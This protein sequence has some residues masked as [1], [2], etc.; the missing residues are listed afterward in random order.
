MYSSVYFEEWKM[1]YAQ[2]DVQSG[3]EMMS[4]DSIPWSADLG[5]RQALRWQPRC[6]IDSSSWGP[7]RL[8]PSCPEAGCP[9]SF[10]Q[11]T[12]FYI[13]PSQA[14]VLE[15][16]SR[17]DLFRWTSQLHLLRTNTQLLGG[18]DPSPQYPQDPTTWGRTWHH[19]E[20]LLACGL[21]PL[22]K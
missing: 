15:L 19:R 4:H 7:T 13:P 14:D 22:S 10:L 9:C 5:A 17:C 20:E 2:Y 8:S 1:P 16:S 3:T 6:R 12:L 21:S 18:R 11:G